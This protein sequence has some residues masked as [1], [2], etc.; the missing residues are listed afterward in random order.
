[1]KSILLE[2]LAISPPQ[3][4]LD[5][6]VGR[7]LRE[8]TAHFKPQASVDTCYSVGIYN[9]LQNL[10]LRTDNEDI[11]LSEAKVNKVC[12]V[13]EYAAEQP[14]IVVDNLNQAI[15]K[16]GYRAHEDRKTTTDHLKRVLEDQT[17]SYPLIALSYRYLQVEHRVDFPRPNPLDNPDHVVVVL[18]VDASTDRMAFYDPYFGFYAPT[19]RD[20]GYGR[21]VVV[22]PVVRMLDD[23]WD[24]AYD[25]S[26]MFWVKWDKS[27]TTRLTSYVGEPQKGATSA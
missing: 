3:V 14:E 16:H 17:C 11:A 25:K 21:G 15:S 8:I 19:S 27:K 24:S 13:K 20:V 2:Q 5:S 12:R 4:L 7:E 10:A 18:M 23:Y 22:K 1:M 6:K 9:I 26:W